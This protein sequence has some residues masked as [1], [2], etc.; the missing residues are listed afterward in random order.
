MARNV[1]PI[2]GVLLTILATVAVFAQNKPRVA[3]ETIVD[4][5]PPPASLDESVLL[6]D[7]IVVGSIRDVQTYQPPINGAGLRLLYTVQVA[8]ILRSHRN[9][10]L[11]DLQVY[12]FGGDIDQG[13]HVTMKVERDFPRFGVGHRYVMFLSWNRVLNGF[14]PKFGPN[15]I[16]ELMPD[17]TVD[18]PGKSSAARSQKGKSAAA[19]IVDIKR[20]APMQ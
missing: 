4:Y 12:R 14:E 16:F 8:D 9:L 18:T 15:G 11:P 7:A 19:L 5:L 17:G 20:A 2:T 6:T 10:T 3:S 13:D 1:K